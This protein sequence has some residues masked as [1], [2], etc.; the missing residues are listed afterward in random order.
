MN[1]DITYIIIMLMIYIISITCLLQ[2]CI[3]DTCKP[4]SDQSWVIEINRLFQSSGFYTDWQ[5]RTFA[6]IS[7]KF[8]FSALHDV[9]GVQ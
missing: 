7:D 2:Y 8:V 6:T 9:Q 4:K 1:E 3:A 5:L